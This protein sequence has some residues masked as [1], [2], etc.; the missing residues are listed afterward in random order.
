TSPGAVFCVFPHAPRVPSRSIDAPPSQESLP[1]QRARPVS[2]AATWNEHDPRSHT[3]PGPTGD[4]AHS[5]FSWA[6]LKH[7]GKSAVKSDAPWS[8]RLDVLDAPA[9]APAAPG[10]SSESAELTS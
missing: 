5:F 3:W 6:T 2:S 10:T 9:E 7:S 1:F 8:L 4:P